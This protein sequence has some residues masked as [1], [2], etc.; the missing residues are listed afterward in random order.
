M[1]GIKT[2]IHIAEIN[3]SENLV[4]TGEKMG[5]A[6]FILVHTTGRF[7]VFKSASAEYIRIEDA[8]IE[9]YKN[10]KILRPTMIYGSS[11]D[12]NIWRR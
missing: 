12:K 5:V 9:S 2:V 3:Y 8:L 10:L 7:S 1:Q 6:W 4:K 11:S